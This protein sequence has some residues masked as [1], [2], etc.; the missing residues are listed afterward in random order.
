MAERRSRRINEILHQI[1]RGASVAALMRKHG[2]TRGEL[3][4]W[5]H[6]YGMPFI[7]KEPT[8]SQL[9]ALPAWRDERSRAK[10][11]VRFRKT[12]L[13][14]DDNAEVPSLDARSD[15]Y[16]N[17]TIR[18]WG[19][20]R[21]LLV[22][23][24]TATVEVL[25]S[26]AGKQPSFTY[27]N[28][29]S[30]ATTFWLPLRRSVEVIATCARVAR[31]PL[32]WFGDLDPQALHWFASVRAGGRDELL[33][34]RDSAKLHLAYVGLDSQWLAWLDRTIP[35]WSWMTIAM[36]HVDREYWHL[37]QRLVP[38]ARELI[39]PRASEMLDGGTKLEV[40]GLIGAHRAV[41][42]RELRRRLSRHHA[43]KRAS[44]RRRP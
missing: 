15:G 8:P 35:Q 25:H 37:V 24:K 16:D 44:Q 22:C 12:A 4:R 11:W 20:S 41:F 43:R 13:A 27:A 28:R 6:T 36:R 14:A 29:A 39:G 1:A 21:V 32:V 10:A 23:E 34:S 9:A 2:F 3:R 5:Q 40:E 31:V 33:A 7:Y 30:T 18:G 42:L 26:W 38:D 17:Y 19:D